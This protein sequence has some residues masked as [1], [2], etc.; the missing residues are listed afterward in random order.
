MN[1]WMNEFL[2]L[3]NRWMTSATSANVGV[4]MK[5]NV[6]IEPSKRDWIIP[7]IGIRKSTFHSEKRIPLSI[8]TTSLSIIETCFLCFFFGKDSYRLWD[9]VVMNHQSEFYF[10]K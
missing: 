9:C 4:H 5:T 1:E 3:M 2:N 6:Y 8:I 10:T 7:T